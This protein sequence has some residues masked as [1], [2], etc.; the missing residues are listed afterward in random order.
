MVEAM[1]DQPDQPY[2]LLMKSGADVVIVE[3]DGARHHMSK[4]PA[5][6]EPVVPPQTNIALLVMSVTLIAAADDIWRKHVVYEGD[7]FIGTAVAGDFS[8]DRLP[9]VI[10]NSGG[11]TRLLVAPD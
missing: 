9:D 8:G 11:K 6:H 4:A 2:E 7:T 5:E 1:R 10:C 3:A